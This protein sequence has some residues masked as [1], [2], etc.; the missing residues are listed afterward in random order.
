MPAHRHVLGL[1]VEVCADVCG[2]TPTGITVADLRGRQDLENYLGVRCEHLD[3]ACHYV[4]RLGNALERSLV[5]W[6]ENAALGAGLSG[7][8][9]T[10]RF[11]TVTDLYVGLPRV[12]LHVV[13]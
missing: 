8:A 3:R 5:R 13:T 1:T 9:T 10:R 12:R 7:D 6:P 11:S 4:A 2:T